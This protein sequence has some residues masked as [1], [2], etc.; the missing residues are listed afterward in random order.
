MYALPSDIKNGDEN[1]L[2]S[3]DL[4]NVMRSS[5]ASTLYFQTKD[6]LTMSRI[7]RTISWS[8]QFSCLTRISRDYEI[9]IMNIL[10]CLQ[11]YTKLFKLQIAI[12]FVHYFRKIHILV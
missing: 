10:N 2:I 4:P 6:D 9:N 11:T 8:V 7:L 3:A 12:T 1:K 5:V